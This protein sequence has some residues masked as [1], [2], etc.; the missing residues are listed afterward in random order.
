MNKNLMNDV[1]ICHITTNNKVRKIATYRSIDCELRQKH[2]KINAFLKR[3]FIPSIFSKGYVQGRS[4]YHNAVSHLYNDYFIMLDIHSFFPSICHK[5]LAERIFYEINLKKDNQISK[6]EC[7]QLIDVCSINKRGLPL[8]FITS[9]VLSNIY[10]KSFDGQ[11]YGFL[12]TLNLENVIYTRY[13]DDLTVSFKYHGTDKN[14]EMEQM[15]I[16][17]ASALLK[18]LGL[19][20]NNHKTRSYNL[21]VSN[22]I[23]ITGINIVKD[24]DNYRKLTVGRALKDKLFREALKCYDTKD[25]T[26]AEQIKGLL[27]FVLSIEKQ[28]FEECYSEKMKGMVFERGF[29]SLSELIQSLNT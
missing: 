6:V 23:R 24:G 15:I 26:N 29:N 2:I 18:K 10:L 27:S 3:R 17:K 21:N 7:N 13:A 11:F 14:P 25:Y 22:H 9:P 20:L 19:Q 1:I 4:I 28:G 12:K 5:Q 16:D 8:G